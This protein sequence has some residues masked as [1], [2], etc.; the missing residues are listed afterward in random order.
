VVVLYLWR[1]FFDL[2]MRGPWTLWDGRFL[3]GLLVL[4][5]CSIVVVG[6]AQLE[7]LHGWIVRP[8]AH[9][10][11]PLIVMAFL[12][13]TAMRLTDVDFRVQALVA[14]AAFAVLYGRSGQLRVWDTL[15]FSCLGAMA[16]SFA[17]PL[18]EAVRPVMP[19]RPGPLG[20]PAGVRALGSPPTERKAE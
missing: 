7:P 14:L 9:L 5:W 13:A 16:L 20:H 8:Y 3:D 19:R 4:L 18:W 2:S 15:V 12:Q 11:T 1:S 10:L 6:V 17:R